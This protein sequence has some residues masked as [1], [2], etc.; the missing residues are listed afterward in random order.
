MKESNGHIVCEFQQFGSSVRRD[1]QGESDLCVASA[2]DIMCVDP[3]Y[4]R[5]GFG[6]LLMEYGVGEADR[7]GVDVSKLISHRSTNPANQR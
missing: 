2:L 1:Y 5:Q 4:H 3:A 7:L 6:S